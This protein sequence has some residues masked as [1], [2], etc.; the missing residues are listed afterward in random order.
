[1][2][3]QQKTEHLKF[4]LNRYDHYIESIQSKS[5]LYIGLNTLMLGGIVTLLTN[6]SLCKMNFVLCAIVLIIAFLSII[7]IIITLFAIKPHLSSGSSNNSI[8]FFNNVSKISHDKYLENIENS[9][10]ETL[11]NDIVNQVHCVA[12][13][14][15]NKYRNLSKVSWL[16]T[17][18][19]A[20]LLIWII[21]FTIKNH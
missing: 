11:K 14:L 12:T 17:I 7:S 13:G 15:T 3:I 21:L 19:F 6:I 16:L 9:T 10:D 20:A 18:Q 2:D 4:I 8:I 5:N 1:M